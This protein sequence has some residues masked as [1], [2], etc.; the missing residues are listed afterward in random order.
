MWGAITQLSKRVRYARTAD[1]TAQVGVST[2]DPV[3]LKLAWR[4]NSFSSAA[5][6]T[7][8]P[9]EIPIGEFYQTAKNILNDFGNTLDEF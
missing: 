6:Y 3:A 1:V 5:G 9:V 8:D 4:A 7:S 2:S